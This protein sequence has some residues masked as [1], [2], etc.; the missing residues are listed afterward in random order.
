[1]HANPIKVD[2]DNNC[3]SSWENWFWAW[4]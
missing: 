4:D 3:F 2:L 1:M